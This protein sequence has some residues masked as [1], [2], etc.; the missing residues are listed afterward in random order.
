MSCDAVSMSVSLWMAAL[1]PLPTGPAQTP[2]V[3]MA[4]VT[5]PSVAQEPLFA[6]I[7]KRAGGLKTKVEAF[8]KA[9]PADGALKPLAGFDDFSKQVAALSDLD[10]QGHLELTKRGVVDDLKCIL[11]GISQDLPVKLKDVSDA[12]SAKDRD[13][14]LR[15]MSYLLNDNVEVITS[16]PQPAA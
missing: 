3:Q 12:K 16:P 7:V 1:A 10:M 9:S 4:I 6:D 13:V 8:R 14:A 2:S 15:E 5:P 11:R